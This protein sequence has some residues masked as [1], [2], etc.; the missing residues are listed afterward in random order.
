MASELGISYQKFLDKYTEEY[1]GIPTLKETETE[2][3]FDCVLLLR[4]L[5]PDPESGCTIGCRVHAHRPAQCRQWPFWPETMRTAKT[6][7]HAGIRCHGI[8]H[9]RH[10]TREEIDSVL[11]QQRDCGDPIVPY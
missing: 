1:E 4:N 9:G 6:W 11:A 7:H 5:E 10:F 2:F 8:D 3:G